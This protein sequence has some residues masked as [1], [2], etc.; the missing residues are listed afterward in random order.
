VAPPDRAV[1]HRWPDRMHHLQE[2]P[3]RHPAE[4]VW[5]LVHLN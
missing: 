1:S 5:G 2:R 4:C 3:L